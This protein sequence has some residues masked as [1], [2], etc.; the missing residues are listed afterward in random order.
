[1]L[2]LLQQLQS[3]IKHDAGGNLA[4]LI[5]LPKS[6]LFGACLCKYIQT[7]DFFFSDSRNEGCGA[8]VQMQEI[9]VLFFLAS[10][11]NA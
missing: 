3:S 9:T 2:W 4:L 7:T 1:M 11:S 8:A 10:D 5:P 6:C